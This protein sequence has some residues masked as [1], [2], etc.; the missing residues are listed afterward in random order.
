MSPCSPRVSSSC[1]GDG[2]RDQVER[3][4]SY[5]SVHGYTQD[6]GGGGGGG[7]GGDA[8]VPPIHRELIPQLLVVSQRGVKA[9]RPDSDEFENHGLCNK[10]PRQRQIT[11]QDHR[12]CSRQH[13]QDWSHSKQCSVSVSTTVRPRPYPIWCCC[14]NCPTHTHTTGT[15]AHTTLGALC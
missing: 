8:G 14:G 10:V 6:R 13:V 15:T 1:Y 4:I 9:R 3:P 12:R 5:T 11:V 7:R 2:Q